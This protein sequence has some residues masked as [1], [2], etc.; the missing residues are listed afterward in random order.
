MG[1]GSKRRPMQVSGEQFARNWEAAFA[2]TQ[3]AAAKPCGR[4]P[5]PAAKRW[6]RMSPRG[7]GQELCVRLDG[8]AAVRR[9]PMVDGPAHWRAL[10]ADAAG[11]LRPLF[12]WSHQSLILAQRDCDRRVPFEAKSEDPRKDPAA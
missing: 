7:T 4:K 6:P 11:V 9:V 8:R 10:E 5:R 2:K 1:K 3:A 12:P